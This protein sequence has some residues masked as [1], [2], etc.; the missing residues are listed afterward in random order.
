MKILTSQNCR[1]RF[2]IP[3]VRRNSLFVEEL[4]SNR[5]STT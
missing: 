3:R 4:T 5:V 1:G 2:L